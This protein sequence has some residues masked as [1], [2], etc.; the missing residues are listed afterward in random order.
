MGR[1][2]GFATDSDRRVTIRIISRLPEF[3]GDQSTMTES[4]A[5][6]ISSSAHPASPRR[7]RRWLLGVLGLTIL[8]AA[9][10]GI[11]TWTLIQRYQAVIAEV[12]RV[13]GWVKPDRGG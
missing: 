11:R 3:D 9:V 12:S 6:P 5:P 2:F 8:I 4:S 7:W 13:G 10:W 1:R